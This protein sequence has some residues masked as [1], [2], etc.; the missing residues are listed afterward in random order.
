MT[1]ERC[2]SVDRRRKHSDISVGAG[3]I[4]EHI[5]SNCERG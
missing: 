4:G 3:G 1:D 2:G 5:Y